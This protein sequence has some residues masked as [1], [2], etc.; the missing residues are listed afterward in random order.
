[1]TEMNQAPLL[2]AGGVAALLMFGK[3][4]LKYDLQP[5]W[6]TLGLTAILYAGLV[7]VFSK[8]K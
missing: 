8:G 7:F 1:M 3:F 4:V 5:D 2:A 6:K